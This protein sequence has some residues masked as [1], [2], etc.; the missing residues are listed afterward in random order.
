MPKRE[1]WSSTGEHKEQAVKLV[2]T[3]GSVSRVARDLDL[4]VSAL[5]NWVRQADIDAGKGSAGGLTSEE[6]VELVRLRR[7]NKVLR[8]ERDFLK[9]AAAYF[10][11]DDDQPS[12]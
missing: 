5:R 9:K 8:M 6:K 11:K 12:S 4:P 10:A 2:R 7:E 3:V 1:R